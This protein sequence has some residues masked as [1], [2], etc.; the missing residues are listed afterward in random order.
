MRSVHNTQDPVK[1][2]AH[3]H[4]A[5]GYLDA[6]WQPL[7]LRSGTK[8]PRAPAWQSRI[9]TTC[10]LAQEFLHNDNIGLKCGT[11]SAGL[12]DVDIDDPIALRSFAS[13]LP[14]TTM[15]HGRASSINCHRWYL[16]DD[17]ECKTEQFRD[18]NGN[19]T[20]IEI[21][22][23]GGQTMVP[24]STHPNGESLAWSGALKPS[25][26]TLL[27]LRNV[28][29]KIAAATILAKHWPEE[30]GR[31]DAALAL[32]GALL[33]AGMVAGLAS[34]FVEWV[35]DAA[36]DEE[37][38]E[39]GA[40]VT[41]TARKM[42]DGEAAT[43]FARLKEIVGAPVAD[44]AFKWLREACLIERMIEW[45]SPVLFDQMTPPDVPAS[46]LPNPL[47][48][49][50]KALA[51]MAEVPEA[52][53][54]FTVLGVVATAVA[55][56]YSVEPKPGWTEHLNIYTAVALPPGNN[57]SLVLRRATEPL[58]LWEKIQ[59][60][61]L[62]PK[63]KE[64]RS[65]RKSEEKIIEK[66]RK[67]AARKD[68][69]TIRDQLL[70]EIVKLE[71]NLTE[72]PVL[73]KLFTNDATPESL[74][75]CVQEQGGYFA[76]ISD[77]GGIIETLG[78]LYSNGVANIDILLKGIDG[79]LHRIRRRDREY[80]LRPILTIL[81]AFQPQILN[82]MAEKRAFCGNGLLDRFLFLCP[83]S[84]LGSRTHDGPPIPDEI[85]RAY[86][87]RIIGL[88]YYDPKNNLKEVNGGTLSLDLEAAQHW[89]AFQAAVELELQQTGRLAEL[90]G[91]GGKLPGF[92]LRIAGLLHLASKFSP[93]MSF[94][95]SAIDK[96]TM[97]QAVSIARLLIEHALAARQ[98]MGGDAATEDAKILYDWIVRERQGRFTRTDCLRSNHGRFKQK[99]RLDAALDVLSQRRIVSRQ[100][101]QPTGRP[102]R[103]A[104]VYEVNPL[105]FDRK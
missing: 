104:E 84:K 88:L 7:A 45:E 39:R 94:L 64:A 78:G 58:R 9:L 29:R 75:T 38:V 27:D 46:L 72:I 74:A 63:I 83:E 34:E 52:L 19:S 85:V 33:R 77:E 81:L 76:I 35:A 60:D 25:K 21:R 92:T 71:T 22:G 99:K 36:N 95:P 73:P 14:Q 24:P 40:T 96:A 98:L 32:G 53:A 59:H 41:R 80:D 48:A 50:A 23:T 55:R 101:R 43:G 17:P 28:V 57:K 4:A 79:G 31:N 12:I 6:G 5:V 49:F 89:R 2:P 82:N 61:E 11:P 56:H 69:P 3:L 66:K 105:V 13:W 42:K 16:V 37:A 87:D 44:T 68:D 70:D 15:Q 26:I 86:V 102:G 30:G 103:P 47:G 65:R 51:D 91:W 93:K 1:E 67:D 10:D 20:I 54:V 97:E 90:Q 8:V 18:P 62:Q 100:E